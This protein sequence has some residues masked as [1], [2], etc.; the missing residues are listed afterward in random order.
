VKT[1][2]VYRAVTLPFPALLIDALHAGTLDAALHYSRR[3]AEAFVAGAYAARLDSPALA[4]R[5]LCLSDQV[6]MPLRSAG[7][8][9]VAVAAHP[10]EA[11]LFGLLDSRGN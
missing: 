6:A 2:D 4:L 3:S 5:Q 1:V 8:P 9:T 10:D 11:S 7:A